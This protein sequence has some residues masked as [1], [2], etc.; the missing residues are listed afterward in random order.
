MEFASA[1]ARADRIGG[2]LTEDQARLLWD[3]TRRLR[4][5]AHVVEIGSHQGRSTVVLALAAPENRLTAIDPFVD[6]RK[7]GGQ[8][9]RAVFEANLAGTGVVLVAAK[10]TDVRPTW[11]EP[12]DLLYVDGKHDYWTCS[13]DLRWAVHLPPG[14]R[15]LVH[16]SFASIGVT[17]A[18]LRH[19]LPSHTLRYVDRTGSLARFE[20]APPSR[21]D[22]VRILRELPWWF[23]N[24]GLK[25]LL[26]LRLRPVARM[27]GHHD[28]ADP[29]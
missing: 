17:L 19:V 8:P 22:R 29:Y 24:V 21:A 28:S 9:T 13:D 7:F 1:F 18:L 15:V 25:V 3:E 16:D 10:S 20:V 11:D 6:G 5:G 2:W 12:F 26:R 4:P 23:R 27:L 14:G